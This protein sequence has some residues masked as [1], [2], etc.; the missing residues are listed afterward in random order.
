[1]VIKAQSSGSTAVTPEPKPEVSL[2][3][4]TGWKR[5]RFFSLCAFCRTTAAT[6]T[7]KIM[8]EEKREEGS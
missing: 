1:M 8:E 5:D 2:W 6:T 7:N 3:E 4:P